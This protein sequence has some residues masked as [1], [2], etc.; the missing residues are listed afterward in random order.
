MTL[1]ALMTKAAREEVTEAE[2]AMLA[3]GHAE[4]VN[5]ALTHIG[6]GRDVLQVLVREAA[7]GRRPSQQ[8]LIQDHDQVTPAGPAAAQAGP[9]PAGSQELRVRGTVEIDVEKG[10]EFILAHKRA[11]DRWKTVLLADFSKLFSEVASPEALLPKNSAAH[12]AVSDLIA[13]L[14]EGAGSVVEAEVSKTL[15]ERSARMKRTGEGM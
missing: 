11:L 1:K 7:A 12:A 15:A 5:T 9:F 2:S 4:R 13:S 8:P 6:R 14:L 10:A 3:A